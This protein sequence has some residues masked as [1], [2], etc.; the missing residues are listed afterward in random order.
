MQLG[1]SDGLSTRLFCSRRRIYMKMSPREWNGT[2]KRTDR[3]GWKTS[4]LLQLIS[5]DWAL[6]PSQGRGDHVYTF[7][8]AAALH[9]LPPFAISRETAL[10]GRCTAANYSIF[11]GSCRDTSGKAVYS[12]SGPTLLYRRIGNRT[13]LDF[14]H[15][16]R[17]TSPEH[18]LDRFNESRSLRLLHAVES[19]RV[20]TVDSVKLHGFKSRK[21]QVVKVGSFCP[22][23]QP[24]H[25]PPHS[26]NISRLPP[27]GSHIPPGM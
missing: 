26:P 21:L 24:D 18:L 4:P 2:S 5:G 1:Q 22:A 19:D 8:H 6:E 9:V 15:P 23:R 16:G 10:G 13:P 12:C 20:R 17:F 14:N 11:P 3:Q 25:D 27:N 7:Q